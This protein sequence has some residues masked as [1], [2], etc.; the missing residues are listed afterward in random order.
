MCGRYSLETPGKFQSLIEP[1]KLK[2]INL[3]SVN[4]N[5]RPT[6]TVPILF[7]GKGGR[8]QLKPAT[9]WLLLD[10]EGKPNN[11]FATFNA[12]LEK[13][14]QS[15]VHQ[16][17]PHSF[18]CVFPMNGWYEWNDG[19][20]HYITRTD[21][22]LLLV[23]GVAKFWGDNTLSCAIATTTA[24]EGLTGVHDRCPLLLDQALAKTWLD[25]QRST[26]DVHLPAF[27]ASPLDLSVF[28]QERPDTHVRHHLFNVAAPPF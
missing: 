14:P 17:R 20:C 7:L 8:Y 12:R 24:Y 21:E 1:F 9:W 11:R 28:K 23:A 26:L 6:D 22:K 2:E 19:Q 3:P 27:N 25:H 18:K 13:F 5:I 10:N 4:P 16:T 15:P